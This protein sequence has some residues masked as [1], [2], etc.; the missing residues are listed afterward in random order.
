M[1]VVAQHG[2]AASLGVLSSE[3]ERSSNKNGM[4]RE[5]INDLPSRG[6]FTDRIECAGCRQ[7][8]FIPNHIAF[9]PHYPVL[10]YLITY[11]LETPAINRKPLFM[12]RF[13]LREDPVMLV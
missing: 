11:L 3:Y 4:T 7:S 2:D 9:Y 8:Y 1:S 5:Y 10:R 6:G 13:G 12:V